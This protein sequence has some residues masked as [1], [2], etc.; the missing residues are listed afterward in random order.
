MLMEP[1]SGVSVPANSRSVV[2]LPAPLRPN[3]PSTS[4]VLSVNDTPEIPPLSPN[5]R[6]RSVAT[7]K[8]LVERCI[9][10]ENQGR[11]LGDGMSIVMILMDIW[12]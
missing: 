2:D 3:S 7:S 8:L 5:F 9:Q 4:P 12:A 6:L 11:I 1:E 10:R